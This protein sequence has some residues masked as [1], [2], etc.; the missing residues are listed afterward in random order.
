MP[1]IHASGAVSC[2]CCSTPGAGVVG[3]L[4]TLAAGIYIPVYLFIAMRRV[5]GQGRMLTGLKYALLGC[6]YLVRLVLCITGVVVY[7]IVNL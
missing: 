3:W 4:A 6:G 7:T 2:R 5:Y 1:W